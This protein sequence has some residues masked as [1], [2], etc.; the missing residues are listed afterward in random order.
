MADK[1]ESSRSKYKRSDVTHPNNAGA[2]WFFGFIG[3]LIYFLHFHSGTFWLVILA[4]LKAIV[5][6]TYLVYYMFQSLNL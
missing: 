3:A 1:D 4:I 5:W 2:V 6:P